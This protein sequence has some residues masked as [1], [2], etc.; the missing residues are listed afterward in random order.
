MLIEPGHRELSLARQC[1]LLELARSSYYYEPTPESVENLRYL[2]LIDEQY[3]RRP[4]YGSRRMSV[5]LQSQGY[6]VNRKRVQRLMRR[7]GL[8]GLAP[9]PRT[10]RPSPEHKVYPYL[11][12]NLEIARPDQVWCTDITYVPMSAGFMYL[13]A[14]MDW[15][16]RY[17]LAWE[18]S[19]TL[20]TAF[21]LEALE[22]AL[23]DARPQIFNSD[24]G[25]QFTSKDF[26]QRLEDAEVSISMDG[27][28]RAFDNIFIER[29]WRTLK[30]EE[31]YLKAYESVAE[32]IEGLSQYFEFY[33]NERLHQGLGYQTPAAVYR[34]APVIQRAPNL[35]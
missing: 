22:A 21:C 17:V 30:Y 14:I 35:S 7:M 15:Y 20:D 29:L 24:Q 26:T 3:L 4:F 10:R 9:G 8:E 2:R 11:L 23:A 18:L 1:E 16:S 34:G 5:W 25:V 6:A 32:L 28:G 27:R 31:I 33:N 13:V 12:R 19:N